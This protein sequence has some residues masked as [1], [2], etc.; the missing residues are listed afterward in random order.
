MEQLQISL[1]D[2][3]NT[4]QRIR[5][6]NQDLDQ[7]LQQMRQIMN[8][9]ATSWQSPAAETIRTKFNGMTPIFQ[10]YKDIVD[11]YAKFLDATVVSY[12]TIE[13]SMQQNASSFQ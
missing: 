1:A 8:Q 3:S 4:A 5:H 9:L 7:T 6:I 13:N 11:S 12:E 10:N 2:V